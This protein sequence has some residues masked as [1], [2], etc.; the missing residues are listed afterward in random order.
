MFDMNNDGKMAFR[1]RGLVWRLLA[2]ALVVYVG[3]LARNVHKQYAYIGRPESQRDTIAIS[4]EGKVTAKP[5]IAAIS[6]GVQ[7]EKRTVSEAQ[8]ENTKRMNAII[9]KM[10][11]MGIAAED[12]KTTNYNIWPAYDY[13]NGRSVE[14]GFTVSQSIDVKVR[15]LD[16]TGKVLAAAGELG[17]NQIGGVNFTIDDP[18]ELRQQARLEALD[19]AKKKAQALAQAAGVKLGKVVGFSESAGGALPIYYKAYAE[20]MGGGGQTTP[21]VQPGSQDVEVNVTVTYEILP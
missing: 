10:K 1:G 18:E 4:A 12:I 14:R 15:N 17:A 5:D 8:D 13:V 16:L 19:A 2:L 3:L 9:E 20:G 11:S 6:I 21:D 7:T